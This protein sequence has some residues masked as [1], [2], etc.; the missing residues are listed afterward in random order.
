MLKIDLLVLQVERKRKKTDRFFIARF[1]LT[2]KTLKKHIHIV[3]NTKVLLFLSTT[4]NNKG[5]YIDI[6]CYL[7]VYPNFNIDIKSNIKCTFLI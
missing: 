6:H 2:T 1:F 4:L 3:I 5:V 7:K